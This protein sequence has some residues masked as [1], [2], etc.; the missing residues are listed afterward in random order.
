MKYFSKLLSLTAA[1]LVSSTVAYAADLPAPV[2][3]EEPELPEIEIGGGWYLR[4]D[5][6]YKVYRDPKTKFSHIKFNDEELDPTGVVGVGVGFR[7]N[8]YI[9]TDVTVDYEWDSDF[10]GRVDCIGACSGGVE[11]SDEFA[12]LDV[13]TILWNVYADLGHYNGFTPYVGAGIG[14]SS[15]NVKNVR[16]INPDGTRVDYPKGHWWNFSWALMAGTSYEINSNW[17]IDAG[18]RYLNI[19]AVKT[20]SFASNGTVSGIKYDNLAAHEVR[21]GLRY[22]FGGSSNQR[23]DAPIVTKY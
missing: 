3:V 14:A 11:A 15:L 21:V 13:W 17:N 22:E 23:Y 1:A 7:M 10:R 5:I 9:R 19:G 16:A 18:Y 12:T 2:F 20:K 6:G 4:G 8:D